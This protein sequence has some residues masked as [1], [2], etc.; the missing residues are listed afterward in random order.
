M[1]LGREEG[2]GS[3]VG[4]VVG[5]M[6]LRGRLA[7]KASCWLLGGSWELPAGG[8]KEQVAGRQEGGRSPTLVVWLVKELLEGGQEQ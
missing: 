7:R 4:G 6:C 2:G 3:G 5:G 8:Q 1:G